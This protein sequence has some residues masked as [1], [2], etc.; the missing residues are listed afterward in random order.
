MWDDKEHLIVVELI[1]YK[2]LSIDRRKIWIDVRPLFSS[3]L[4]N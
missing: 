4:Y 3:K 2:F 1:S